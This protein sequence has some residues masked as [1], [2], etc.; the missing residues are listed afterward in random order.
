MPKYVRMPKFGGVYKSN[1]RMANSLVF[2][3]FGVIPRIK[4]VT[5][6]FRYGGQIDCE[7]CNIKYY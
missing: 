5:I 2:D 3:E 6:M 4:M 7:P 1:V